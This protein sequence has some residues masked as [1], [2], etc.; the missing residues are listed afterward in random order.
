MFFMVFNKI[1][2]KTK[3]NAEFTNQLTE[4][5]G[6]EATTKIGDANFTLSL[7]GNNNPVLVMKT[8]GSDRYMQ[9]QINKAGNR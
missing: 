6:K 9:G 7:S 4:N 3:N 2:Y 1:N 8:D 5:T